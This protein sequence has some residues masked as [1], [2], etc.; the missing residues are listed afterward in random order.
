MFNNIYLTHGIV[1]CQVKYIDPKKM[2]PQNFKNTIH[3]IFAMSDHEDVETLQ[4]TQKCIKNL[5]KLFAERK[6]KG[7]LKCAIEV[8]FEDE[9]YARATS[10]IRQRKTALIDHCP[11]T[12]ELLFY[13][14]EQG[15]EETIKTVASEFKHFKP[16]VELIV[17]EEDADVRRKVV[18][19]LDQTIFAGIFAGCEDPAILSMKSDDNKSLW[20]LKGKRTATKK[21]DVKKIGYR[22]ER[23]C[24]DSKCT[25]P[26]KYYSGGLV[27]CKN[28]KQ[29]G[30]LMMDL[31][32]GDDIQGICKARKKHVV[33]VAEPTLSIV[34]SNGKPLPY[35]PNMLFALIHT[36]GTLKD[37]WS[38]LTTPMVTTDI[39]KDYSIS[40]TKLGVTTKGWTL[41]DKVFTKPD[42]SSVPQKEGVRELCREYASRVKSSEGFKRLQRDYETFN[43]TLVGGRPCKRWRD[44]KRT[45]QKNYTPDMVVATLLEQ[46]DSDDSKYPWNV[47]R[48]KKEVIKIEE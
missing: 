28:H 14:L 13:A 32:K 35:E 39:H 5:F 42:K 4:H 20:T 11:M 26:S 44:M 23:I 38:P 46:P 37:S 1:V 15:D 45:F 10:L 31:K 36:H 18:E 3:K 24:S 40:P 29:G 33:K 47:I 7:A 43:I 34:R 6:N 2:D 48:V 17:E 22:R 16:L 8:G 27:F 9:V 12:Y 30:F 25:T 41:H 21:Y 19:N